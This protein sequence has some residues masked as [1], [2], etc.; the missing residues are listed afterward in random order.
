MILASIFTWYVPENLFHASSKSYSQ[1]QNF[2]AK[3]LINYFFL[4]KMN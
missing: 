1:N 4:S 3:I 2:Y